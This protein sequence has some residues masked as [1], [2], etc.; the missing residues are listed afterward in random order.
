MIPDGVPRRSYPEG[1]RGPNEDE[2]KLDSQCMALRYSRVPIESRIAET[3]GNGQELGSWEEVASTQVVE[4]VGLREVSP[5][6]PIDHSI[7]CQVAKNI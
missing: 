3:L 6:F 2:S 7:R 1:S 5:N 4:S